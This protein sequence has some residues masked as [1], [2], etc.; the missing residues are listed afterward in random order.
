MLGGE[1]FDE[2]TLQARPPKTAAKPSETR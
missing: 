2:Y 1:V